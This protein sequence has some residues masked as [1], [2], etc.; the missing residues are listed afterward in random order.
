MKINIR[1][2][3]A[4]RD[5]LPADQKGRATLELAEKD[6]VQALLKIIGIDHVVIVA[7]NGQQDIDLSHSL[8][9]GDAVTVFELVGGG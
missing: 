1:L 8:Q 6:T 2:Y 3:G 5:H 4:L 9:D 7:V